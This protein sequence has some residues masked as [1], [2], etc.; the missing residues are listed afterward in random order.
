[1]I[2]GRRGE[3]ERPLH[4]LALSARSEKGLNALAERY[5]QHLTTHPDL[6]MADVAFTANTGR[7]HFEHRL[8]LIAE[9]ATEA[10]EA[11]MTA[12][13]SSNDFRSCS[14]D[15]HACPPHFSRSFVRNRARERLK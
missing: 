4:L 7:S 12:R 2:R 8:T 5:V 13:S 15:G 10:R 14:D 3:G 11:L 1:M 6:A 9:S